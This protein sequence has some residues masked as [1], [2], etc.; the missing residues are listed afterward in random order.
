LGG[1]SVSII[2]GIGDR[3]SNALNDAGVTNLALLAEA[4]PEVIAAATG[5]GV[6]S[7]TTWINQ[8]Q[9]LLRG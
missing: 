8:A 7:A 1:Q 4:Q 9:S 2:R 3:R 5:V 6:S